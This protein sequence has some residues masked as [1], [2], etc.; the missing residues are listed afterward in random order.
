M[1]NLV[2]NMQDHHTIQMTET[3]YNILSLN[4]KYHI[5]E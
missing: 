1:L 4:N 3:L 2:V 5:K